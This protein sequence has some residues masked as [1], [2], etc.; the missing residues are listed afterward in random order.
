MDLSAY[1]DHICADYLKWQK[2]INEDWVKSID[3]W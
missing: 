1:L 3:Q 2:F